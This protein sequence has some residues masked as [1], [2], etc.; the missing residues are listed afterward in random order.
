MEVQVR[1]PH[2]FEDGSF[3]VVDVDPKLGVKAIVGKYEGRDEYGFHKFI[4]PDDWSRDEAWRYL[5][6]ILEIPPSKPIFE[7]KVS[8]G[9]LWFEKDDKLIIQGEAIH[10]IISRNKVVY[11]E[12]ELRKAARTLIGKPLCLNHDP[13]QVVGRIVNAWFDPERRA[14][15]YQAIVEDPEIAELVRK[16]EIKTVSIGASFEDMLTIDRSFIMPKGIVFD[17]L[18]LLHNAIPGDRYASVQALERFLQEKAGK[19]DKERENMSK[20]SGES[21]KE[22]VEEK[23]IAEE[24]K[25]VKEEKKSDQ[26]LGHTEEE[27]NKSKLKTYLKYTIFKPRL[28][29]APKEINIYVIF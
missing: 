7:I 20:E 22:K 17:E 8:E 18:S 2:E 27:E 14:I 10:T 9:K 4:F 25:K 15:V 24:E 1:P 5:L 12:E 26:V 16:G 19:T 13:R 28:C 6:A 3:K 29:Y 11:D 23:K 21:S